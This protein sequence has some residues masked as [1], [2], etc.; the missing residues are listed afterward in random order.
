M[1]IRERRAC[2]AMRC[3]DQLGIELDGPRLHA[4]EQD[5]TMGTVGAWRVWAC[6]G[7][8]LSTS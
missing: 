1:G 2:R 6:R 4:D 8:E 7:S 3:I 5:R